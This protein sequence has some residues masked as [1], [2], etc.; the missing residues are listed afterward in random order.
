[1][2][3]DSV[4]ATSRW[5]SFENSFIFRIKFIYEYFVTS[6]HLNAMSFQPNG[7]NRITV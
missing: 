4:A 6:C 7:P 2:Q 1:M 5:N 3:V